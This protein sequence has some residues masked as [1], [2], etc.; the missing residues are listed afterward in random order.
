MNGSQHKIVGIGFGI[1]ASYAC[2]KTGNDAWS[3]MCVPMS[4][5]GCMLPDIDHDMTKIGRKRKLATTVTNTGLTIM[6]VLGLAAI[7][8]IAV[9]TTLQLTNY[10]TNWMQLAI[11]A[12]CIIGFLVLRSI[13]SNNKTIKWMTKHRGLMH[14]LVMPALLFIAMKSTNVPIM[15]SA[16]LGTL[17]GYCSHLIA[18]CCTKDGCPLLWPITKKSIHITNITT[19]QKGVCNAMA[20]GLCIAAL[21]LVYVMFK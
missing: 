8:F 15:Y 16:L 6:C 9:S 19:K 5:V 10:K 13:L 18:D 21:A 14:T 3:V 11:M 2:L 12:G 1:A 17:I 4:M 20:F 7:G